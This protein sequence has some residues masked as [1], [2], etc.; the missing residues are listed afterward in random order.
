MKLGEIWRFCMP[1]VVVAVAGFG[2]HGI[3]EEGLIS[4][5][6]A[7]VGALGYEMLVGTREANLFRLQKAQAA[8]EATLHADADAKHWLPDG[9]G[10][11][12]LERL[13]LGVLLID[14]ESQVQFVNAAGIELF[15]RLPRGVFHAAQLRAPKLLAA[16]EECGIEQ[17]PGVADF[18]LMRG[19]DSHLRAHLQP[20]AWEGNAPVGRSS[21]L[22]VIEDMTRFALADEVY[23]DFV[24]NASHELKTPLASITGLI[25]TL[26]GH[27]RDDEAAR[28]RFLSVMALQAERM[29]RLIEDMMSL[30]RIEQNE[31]VLPRTPQL[32]GD[33][34]GET[35]DAM[36]PI[37]RAAEISLRVRLPD[38][39]ALVL[40][41]REELGQVFQNL[42]DNAIKYGRAG[43]SVTVEPVSETPERPGMIGIGVADTGPGIAREHLPR[44][45]QR[46]YRVSAARSRERGGTGLGL[47]I[48]KHIVNRHRGHLQIESEVG[49]GSCFTVWL[50]RRSDAGRELPEA[51]RPM[52]AA[53]NGGDRGRSTP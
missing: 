26:Q 44:L 6:A 48:V 38:P 22:V 2:A 34:V 3:W 36:M 41:S 7:V 27:A 8:K 46:F 12:L 53:L 30:Q 14:G 45:T 5:L 24:A 32:L 50:P 40:G 52:V 29:R 28:A 20:L 43:D 33:L 49:T 39:G 35:V 15:G 18:T 17:R 37:A 16:L 10:R 25:E 4:L 51:D 23:R 11:D 9:T 19:A 42:I 21:V 31:R 47:A 1:A 13:P